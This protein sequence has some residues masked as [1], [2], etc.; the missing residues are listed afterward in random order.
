ML[1]K[2]REK[3]TGIVAWVIVILISIPFA[4]WG[5]NSYFEGGGEAVVATVEGVDIDLNTFQQALAERRRVLTQVLQ[6][7]PGSEFFNSPAFRNQVLE[8]L[9]QNAALASYAEQKGYRISDQVL[10]QSIRQLPYFVSD[11]AFDPERYQTLVANAGMSVARFEQQQRQELVSDQIRSAFSDSAFV[12]ASDVDRTLV[13]L[14]Q[15]RTAEYAVMS[16]NDPTIEVTVTEDELRAHY[17][18]NRDEFF[19]PEQIR[20]DYLV[21]SVDGIAEMID[22][23][24]EELRR[25]H[26]NNPGRFGQPEQRRV[27]HILLNVAADADE[28]VE[29]AVRLQAEELTRLAR[30]GADFA[31]LAREHS[32][33]SGSATSGGDLGII[34]RG[35]MVKPFEDQ[36][37][38]LAAAGDVS[39]PVRS[40]FGYHVIKLT[41]YRPASVAPFEE[42][43][44]EIESEIGRQLAERQ[45]LENAETFSA[46]VYEQPESLEP[47][48]AE[49]QLEVQ[50]SD[51]FSADQGEGIAANPRVRSAAFSDDVRIEGLNSDAFELDAN[52]M[53]AVRRNE[54][55]EQRS[56]AFDEVSDRIR[57]TL[58]RQARA[59]T[60]RERGEA[61]LAAIESGTD[62]QVLVDEHELDA[63]RYEGTRNDAADS[64]EQQLTETLFALPTPDEDSSTSGGFTATSGDFVI[65]RLTDV[66]DADPNA[67]DESRREEV[68]NLLLSRYS[69]ELYESF[70]QAL[71]EGAEV[72]VYDER[73]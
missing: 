19:A 38:A 48:A 10:G 36:A 9:V 2:I 22:V 58:G 30:E 23:D 55:R 33:D 71:R 29:E 13:L 73:F 35:A 57:S 21:L 60:I 1:T 45:F 42:V 43:R 44:D 6:Q 56:L 8:G 3:A 61:L 18:E 16:V 14:E 20:V 70:Q 72:Q 37:Y 46:L 39:D 27:S 67:V 40:Q 11:G 50:T 63:L 26:E 68:R 52:T 4:L 31:E 7:N 53:V 47:A 69:Q 28:E 32:D 65:Y 34:S 49:L 5:I 54:F 24:E 66:V 12:T 25:Y 59:N 62:W 41:E 15:T 64:I 17:E 51:W